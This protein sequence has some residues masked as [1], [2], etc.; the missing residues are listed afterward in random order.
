MP[1]FDCRA[2]DPGG[3]MIRLRIEAESQGGAA[4]EARA[5]GVTLISLEE[6]GGG[7]GFDAFSPT[8]FLPVTTKDKVLLFRML[9]TLVKSEVTVTQAIRILHDQTDRMNVKA[10]LAEVLSRV[11][12][13]S[14]LSDALS[15]HPRVF[16]PMMVNLIRAGEMGG[17]LDTVF[18]RIADYIER[19]SSL[20]KKLMMSFFYPGIVLVVGLGV[21]VFMVLFVIPRF[22]GLIQGKL[23]PVTQFLMDSTAF[24]QDNGLNMLI[25]L[26]AGI[27]ALAVMHAVPLTRYYLDRGKVYLPVIGPIIRLGV[28]VSFSRTFSLL[29]ESRIPMVEALRATSAT[30]PNTAVNAFLDRTVDRVMAGEPLSVTLKESWAFTPITMSMAN[31]GEH[32]GLMSESMLTVAEVHEKLLEDKIARMSAM[33]EP[34]LILTLGGVVGLVVYGLISGMLAMYAGSM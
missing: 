3:N 13:G 1:Y 31:I 26:G 29:L 6:A 18:Q 16:S 23:P 22:M 14:P 21:V 33:V 11:E 7:G 25:G 19:R 9:A 12:G 20:R 15:H 24:L 2:M 10:V 5:R 4:A 32:S 27:G 8:R 17:I 34:A 28:V 30:I